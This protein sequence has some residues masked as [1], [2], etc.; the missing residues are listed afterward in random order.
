VN[1]SWDDEYLY[2][3]ARRLSIAELQFITYGEYLDLIFGPTLMKY[4]SLDVRHP[5]YSYYEKHTDPTTWNDYA[6]AACRFGHSQINNFFSLIGNHAIGNYTYGG[7]KGNNSL[8]GFYLRDWFFDPAIIYEGWHDNMVRGLTTDRSQVVDPWIANDVKNYLYRSKYERT[9]SD[10]PAFNIQRGRDH[11]LPAYYVY[12]EFC[13]GFKAYSWND[14][15]KFIPQYQLKILMGLYE[16]WYDV[17]LWV[18]GMS[19]KKFPDADVGP[20]FACILGIQYYHLKFGD[21][22]FVTHGHQTGSF[23]PAQLSNIRATTTLSN[24]LCKTGDYL[25]SMQKHAF[26][27]A[28]SYNP[29]VPCNKYAEIDYSLWKKTY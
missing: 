15:G 29:M 21:R 2:Q 20:T 3:E 5:G 16:S 11:G 9:G 10:L 4:Y 24:V 25:G 6:A 7:Y 26:F 14:L 27:P 12:L 22:Y 17:D 18:A 1:P 19:E 8:D 13:F 23:T 28:S